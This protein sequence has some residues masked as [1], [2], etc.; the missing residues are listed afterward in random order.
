MIHNET[1]KYSW[2]VEPHEH[3][4]RSVDW[5]WAMSIGVLAIVI[6]AVVTRNYLFAFLM[7]LGGVLVVMSLRK[8]PDDMHVEISEQ[9]ISVNGHIYQ[10]P[11]IHSFWLYKDLKERPNLLIHTNRSIF[12]KI[13]I[14]LLPDMDFVELHTFLINKIE[15]KEQYESSIDRIADRLEL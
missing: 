9:A 2:V 5:Y 14:P 8:K 15:E 4:R 6:L 3:Y 12:P 10:Y 7:I 13:V 1:K 11:Q